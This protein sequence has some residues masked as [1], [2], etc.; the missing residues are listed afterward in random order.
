M[1]YYI[2]A[3]H[4]PTTKAFTDEITSKIHTFLS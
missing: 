3:G 2:N 1:S 4:R